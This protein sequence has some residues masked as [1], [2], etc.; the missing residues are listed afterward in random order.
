MARQI[1]EPTMGLET[2]KINIRA[3]FPCVVFLESSDGVVECVGEDGDWLHTL[4]W[5]D[6]QAYF[7][8]SDKVIGEKS[9]AKFLKHVSTT[10]QQYDASKIALPID[11]YEERSVR[12]LHS[13][14][15]KYREETK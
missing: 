12:L 15:N 8:I 9:L 13:L 6:G 7:A 10:H 4:Y 5:K 14:C 11:A 2:Y 1:K 3:Y